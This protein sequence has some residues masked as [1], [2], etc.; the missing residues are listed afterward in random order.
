MSTS[1]KDAVKKKKSKKKIFSRTSNSI[2]EEKFQAS[3]HPMRQDMTQERKRAFYCDK[4]RDGAFVLRDD[5]GQLKPAITPGDLK[6]VSR[7]ENKSIIE[8]NVNEVKNIVYHA[9]RKKNIDYKGIWKYS[10]IDPT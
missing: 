8:S 10:S 1:I 6:I 7:Y 2:S 9:V 5:I 4:N 3:T